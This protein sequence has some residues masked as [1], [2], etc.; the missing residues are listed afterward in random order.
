MNAGVTPRSILS[1]SP[2]RVGSWA[3][4]PITPLAGARFRRKPP[5]TCARLRMTADPA[6]E[7][8]GDAREEVSLG[9]A[10]HSSDGGS[11]WRRQLNDPQVRVGLVT[12]ACLLVEAVIAKNVL[13]VQLDFFSQLAPMWIF[14]VYQVSGLRDRTSEIAFMITIVLVTAAI[15]DPVRGLRPSRRAASP[16]NRSAS[17]RNTTSGQV[18]VHREAER[19][20]SCARGGRTTWAARHRARTRR[21]RP[22]NGPTEPRAS[23]PGVEGLGRRWPGAE[24]PSH[25]S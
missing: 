14:I 19:R 7:I 11:T 5:S 23:P 10:I 22:R 12:A 13:D 2:M 21:R 9:T 15:L 18:Q 24:A 1:G 20:A 4:R 25:F 6:P 16:P 17:S 8:M 3:E